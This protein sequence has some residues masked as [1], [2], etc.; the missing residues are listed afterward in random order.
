MPLSTRDRLEKSFGTDLGGVRVHTG[1][2]AAATTRELGAEAFAT[3]PDIAFGPGRFSPGTPQGDHLIAEEVAHVIQQRGGG[4][5]V[6]QRHA[7]VSN[8]SDSAE[9]AA[10]AAADRVVAGKPAQLSLS[11]L[12]TRGRIMRRARATAAPV[13]PVVS[14]P[15]SGLGATRPGA[16]P[17]LTPTMTSTLSPAGGKLVDSAGRRGA[18]PGGKTGNAAKAPD[19]SQTAQAESAAGPVNVMTAGAPVGGAA[20]AG[21]KAAKKEGRKKPGKDRNKPEGGAREDK[22]KRS[23][24]P[25]GAAAGGGGGGR[26]GKV[27][28]DRGA[29]A[30]AAASRR[31]DDRADALATNEGAETRI[32]AA[33]AAA[34]P[35]PNAAEAAGQQGQAGTLEQADVPAGD[36]DSARAASRSVVA[37]STPGSIEDLE[38]FASPSGAGRRQS[39]T[40]GI[41]GQAEAQTGPVRTSL[42]AIDNPPLGAAPPPAVP[43]AEPLGAPASAEPQVAAAV[44][45]PVNEEALDASEFKAEADARLEEH[46]AGDETLRKAE[47]GPLREIGNDKD[48]LNEKVENAGTRARGTE[49]AARTEASASLANAEAGAQGAMERGRTQGQGGVSAEQESTRGGDEAAEQSLADQI[50]S[51]YRTAQTG[52][53]EKLSTLTS[54]SVSSFRERQGARLE[55]FA[56][57]VR[58]DL[59]DL[60]RRRY[61][62]LRGRARRVRDWFLS[63]NSVPEVQRL[64]Q[65]HR[66]QY[67]SDIDQLITD[68]KTAIDQTIEACKTALRT[69]REAIEQL[70]ASNQSQMDE[71]ARA[72]LQ[73]AQTGFQQMEQQI[74]SAATAAKQALDTE[75][76]RA[77]EAMDAELERIRSE[78][79]G[80]VDK[81]ANAIA[82]VAAALGQFMRLMTRVTRMGIGAFLSAALSQAQSGVQ[83]NLWGELQEAFKQWLFMKIPALQL[84]LSLPPNWLEMLTAL[85]TNLVG[86]FT[87]NLPAML[88]AIGAAA[89][90]WLATT[91]A[92]KLIPGV[93]AIMAVIDAVRGAYALVQSLFSAASAFFQF[94]MKVADRGNGAVEFARA[95]AFGIVAA[96]DAVLT[97]LG[98]DRLIR[99]VVGAIARPFGRIIGRVTR[100]FRAFMQ[101]R[102]RRRSP[103][104]TRGRQQRDGGRGGDANALRR[105]RSRARSSRRNRRRRRASARRNRNRQGQRGQRRESPSERRRRRQ[106][107]RERRRAERLRRAVAFVTPR[108]QAMLRRGTPKVVLRA[109]LAIWRVRFRIRRLHADFANARLEAANSPTRITNRWFRKHRNEIYR[110]V[111]EIAEQRYRTSPRR[112]QPRIGD[113]AESAAQQPAGSRQD[114]DHAGLPRSFE[115]G[116]GNPGAGNTVFGPTPTGAGRVRGEPYGE[117]GSRLQESG[118]S[119]SVVAD[120]MREALRGGAASSADAAD[121]AAIAFGS[122]VARSR[123]GGGFAE[124]TTRLGLAGLQDG[125]VTPQQLFGDRESEAGFRDSRRAADQS[126]DRNRSRESGRLRRDLTDSERRRTTASRGSVTRRQRARRGTGGLLP[127]SM[128]G[129]VE[130]RSAADRLTDPARQSPARGSEGRRQATEVINRT[131]QLVARVVGE[132]EYDS[133]ST[134]LA[135]V[136]RRVIE[137]MSR[138]DND[139]TG[140]G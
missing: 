45:P 109:R 124:V 83:N 23:G 67:I 63:I 104:R 118:G 133:K 106:Q 86:L 111:R 74:E 117:L 81:V 84:L 80:L 116:S 87:E 100:R 132:I 18:K 19:E 47:E 42:S 25:P 78:N 21:A 6:V 4:G 14:V 36:P 125:S 57:G 129:F 53:N 82:A 115:S 71:A 55:A 35:P 39:L 41:A 30:A 22:N 40:D 70:V 105:A 131:V 54:D 114:L 90:I 101:R 13:S 93:G 51:T 5:Q 75:R 37:A 137:V 88:P 20:T 120:Q 62:G 17:V 65:R 138:V 140:V 110:I 122:D 89:M 127:Q 139:L 61:S 77:I 94:V 72:A 128:K 112:P 32:D 135:E 31:L 64:Y 12:T 97:F 134:F 49:V 119:S 48:K 16:V 1:A 103:Q 28:G 59:A 46:D 108:V 38:A 96:V 24:G 52:V 130:G 92:A 9:I 15:T 34:A 91:L 43:L 126:R 136:R 8:A 58:A 11:G 107:E 68:I 60:K 2:A 27:K 76:R 123:A 26:F 98:V 73:R 121:V 33:Q 66:D 69:A 10:R 102:R 7:I 50:G 79:A 99:R 95:L 56:S 85:A 44:P 29:G 3:G 113:A